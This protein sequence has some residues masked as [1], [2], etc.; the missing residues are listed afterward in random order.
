MGT[1]IR[2][3]SS[4]KGFKEGL[5]KAV[6]PRETVSTA[7]KRLE[8]ASGDLFSRTMRIDSGRLDIPV[9]ISLLGADGIALTGTAKQMGKGPT[10]EQAEASAIMELIERVS[11]FSFMNE[12]RGFV[13]AAGRDLDKPYLGFDHLAFALSDRGPD[14]FSGAEIYQRA[15]LDFVPCLSIADQREIMIPFMWFYLI[16]E[17]NGPAA[18]NSLEE[19]ALQALCEVVERHVGTLISRH[20]LKTPGIAP[21]SLDPV[22]GELLE[23]FRRAGVEVFLRDFSMDTGIPSVGALAYDPATFPEK[24][25][26]VFTAGT[27]SSPQQACIRALTEVAQLAGDFMNKTTYKP[28]LPKYPAAEEAAYLTRGPFDRRLEDLP[29]LSSDDFLTELEDAARAAAAAGLRPYLME[30]THPEIGLPACYV[31]IPG[32]QFRERTWKTPA[33]FHLAKVVS[34]TEDPTSLGTLTDMEEL[35]SDRYYVKFF[36]GLSLERQERHEDALEAYREAVELGAPD[37]DAASLYVHLGVAL[38]ELGRYDEAIDA[39]K[40]ARELQDDLKEVYN[41][42]G[43]C[44]FK[45]GE[46]GRSIEVF[47]RAIELDPGSGIDYANIGSNLRELGRPRDAIRLYR[48]ALEI[49]PTLDFARENISVLEERLKTQRSQT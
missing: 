20:R 32:A 11:F 18:G 47:E 10:P 48:M 7:R 1:K 9:Y 29:D 38:K 4:P 27:A 34:L 30:T 31:V 17:F 14:L 49:D 25:E 21:E 19:A 43:F 41:L 28:T 36:K 33:L 5:E 2:L 46:H 45:L 8:A 15:R 12:Q 23:K 22:S 26:I 3:K 24:S 13:R 39:L 6:D 44:Y 37:P 35:F 16:N 40:K 42:L